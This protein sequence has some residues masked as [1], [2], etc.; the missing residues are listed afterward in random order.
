MNE[1]S[2][3]ERK[4]VYEAALDRYGSY[5]Q[6]WMC[7]EEMSE[8]TKAICK[9]RRKADTQ[10]P[11]AV[12]AVAEEIADVTIMLEQAR[13]IFNINEEVCEIMDQ[14]I[15]RLRNRLIEEERSENV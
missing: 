13:L 3:E 15:E 11:E 2:Y 7:V 12:A 9:I 14:K 1:V 4:K 6:L 5:A 8:L 10:Y